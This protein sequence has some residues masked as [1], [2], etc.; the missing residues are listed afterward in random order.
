[1]MHLCRKIQYMEEYGL[2]QYFMYTAYRQ[3]VELELTIT[4]LTVTLLS[5]TM[6]IY[7]EGKALSSCNCNG[8]FDVIIT[9]VVHHN[10]VL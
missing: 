10:F 6:V 1:M 9:N 3:Q 7:V 8:K 4:C 5:I 2:C